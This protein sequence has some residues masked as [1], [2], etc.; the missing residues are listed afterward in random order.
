MREKANYC[1]FLKR[2]L[3]IQC[4]FI[5]RV[6]FFFDFLI[7]REKNAKKQGFLSTKLAIVLDDLFRIKGEKNAKI[8][9]FFIY[10]ISSFSR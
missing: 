7:R 4:F 5:Y 2:D 3:K 10:K 9:C 6:D 8:Q 1:F